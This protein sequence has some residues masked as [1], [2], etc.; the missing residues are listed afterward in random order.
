M[1]MAFLFKSPFDQKIVFSVAD[2]LSVLT[3]KGTLRKRQ[4][5]DGIYNVGL[6][7]SIFAKQANN[8]FIKAELCL[9]VIAKILKSEVLDLH[10]DLASGCKLQANG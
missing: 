1:G 7:A 9:V 4:I 3:V 2:V 6:A 5:M 10:G 8:F